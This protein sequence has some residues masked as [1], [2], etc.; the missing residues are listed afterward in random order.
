MP[1]VRRHNVPEPVLRHLLTRIR[2]R[3]I[4]HTQLELLA[5]WLDSE[6]TVPAGRWFRRFPD[7]IVCG[8]GELLKTF[9]IKNQTPT[10]EEIP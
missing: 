9:L 7:M 4:S 8:E 5:Q 10:G 6:P 1:K 3:E 2:Q